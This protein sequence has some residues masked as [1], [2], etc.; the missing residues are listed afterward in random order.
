MCAARTV[1]Y[2]AVPGCDVTEGIVA[3][4]RRIAQRV[5]ASDAVNA[6][7]HA[8]CFQPTAPSAG[9]SDAPYTQAETVA[10]TG[11]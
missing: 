2:R 3:C 1:A 9:A 4:K 6:T 11:P 10:T 7:P 8:I 5:F